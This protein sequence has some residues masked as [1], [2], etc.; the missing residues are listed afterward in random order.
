[1]KEDHMFPKEVQSL[2]FSK[3]RWEFKKAEGPATFFVQYC[4]V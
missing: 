3:A 4:P 1:M 2:M